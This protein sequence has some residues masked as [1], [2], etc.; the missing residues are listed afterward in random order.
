MKISTKFMIGF[1]GLALAACSSTDEPA[2]NPSSPDGEV[3]YMA[4]TIS[5]PDGVG[6]RA[7]VEGDYESSKDVESEHKV[8][9]VDFYF[10]EKDGTYAFKAAAETGFQ[11][12]T[13]SNP[14]VEYIGTKQILILN[15]VRTNDYPE[16]VITVINAPS[17]FTPGATMQETADKLANFDTKGAFVMTTSSFYGNMGV[18]NNPVQGAVAEGTELRHDAQYYATKL[19]KSD[20]KTTAEDATNTDSPVQIYVERL[21]AK[22]QLSLETKNNSKVEFDGKNYY[23]KLSQ[24]LGGGDNNTTGDGN[25]SQVDLYVKV[26]GWGLNATAK[27]SYMSKKLDSTWETKAPFTA[28]VWNKPYDWRSF[29]AKSYTYGLTST[30][31]KG[32][33]HDIL[34]YINPADVAAS[35]L[36]LSNDGVNYDYCYENTNLA[37]NILAE[38]DGGTYVDANGKKVGVKNALTTHVVLHTQIYQKKDGKFVPAGELVQY[39]GILYTGDSYKNLLLNRIKNSGRLNFWVHPNSVTATIND[40]VNIDSNYLTITRSENE[41]RKLGE[42]VVI[43]NTTNWQ[44]VSYKNAEGKYQAF[45]SEQEF[46]D[47]LTKVLAEAV[48][49]DTENPA[50]GSNGNADAL[51]YIPIEHAALG[52]NAVDGYFGVVRNHWYQLK[53]NSFKK[54]GHLVFDPDTD[55]TPII[56]EDPEDP[57]YY[58]GAKINILSWKVVSQTVTDL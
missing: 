25:Q 15:G 44:K 29:W 5:A 13:G 42:I 30:D 28:W 47:A 37:S 40:W 1:A 53:I 49:A 17:N 36:G 20:F 57:M 7:T 24:T 3:A 38:V 10:F 2:I 34:K 26:I 22:V 32:D 14:N 55:T 6:T 4:I 51:Y 50:V 12:N 56:P 18:D 16:Y 33:G 58:V 9:S 39:R 21:D 45:K 52:N 48:A 19:N 46:K 41:N 8:N 11:E 27:D 35:T 31:I 43:P 23:F 54:V